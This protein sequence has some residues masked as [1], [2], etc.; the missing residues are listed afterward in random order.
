M[1]SRER[2]F[3]GEVITLGRATDQVLALKD[4]RVDLE[5]AR[6]LFSGGR[7]L[8]T[9]RALTGVIVNGAVCRDAAIAVGDEIQIGSNLLRILEPAAGYDLALTFELAPDADRRDAVAVPLRL[10]LAELAPGKRRWSWALFLVIAALGLAIPWLTSP[11]LP[12]ASRSALLPSDRV[13]LPGPL[14]AA[15]STIALQC[16]QCHERPFVQVR[17]GACLQCHGSALHRH[18]ADQR[19]ALPSLTATRCAQCHAEHREP[20]MLVRSDAGVCT[21]C[22]ADP[23][24]VASRDTGLM[25]IKDFSASHPEF[26][27]TL[28]RDGTR[29]RLGTARLTE[30]SGLK[31]SH[32]AHLDPR[33]IRTPEGSEVLGCVDCHRPDE[34][35]R[36]LQPVSMKR[37]CQG[38]HALSFDPAEPAR[39]VPHGEPARVLESLVEYYS[40]RY[41]A[42]YPDALATAGSA[43]E[44]RRPGVGLDAG[45]RLR[46][47]TTARQRAQSVAR[48]LFERRTCHVCHDV[49]PIAGGGDWQVAKVSLGSRWMPQ[50][51]FS[52]VAHSTAL[53]PCSS[54]HAAA[55]SQTSADVLMP[56]IASCRGCH[57]DGATPVAGKVQTACTTCHGFHNERHPLWTAVAR[58]RGNERAK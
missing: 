27:V 13:W 17:D 11:Q 2:D 14:H 19:V 39:T 3:V 51:N 25:A 29:A 55:R 50:A 9:S 7:P 43:R 57:A 24:A 26:R 4:R 37:D 36:G 38:C 52:H 40:A 6:I 1:E 49:R 31:F 32:A 33:G 12:G 42:G 45:E 8:I 54:C 58:T 20:A 53:T 47:L 5:H 23:A 41:L 56:G 46:L 30:S 35:G 18:V 48:D 21:D 10:T 28:G 15:H 44:L 34:S 16:E 22:H